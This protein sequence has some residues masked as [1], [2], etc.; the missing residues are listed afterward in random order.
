MSVTNA[1]ALHHTCILVNDL[2]KTAEQ[3]AKALGV[4]WSLWTIAPEQCFVNGE[5][6]PFSF[7]VGF[8]QIGDA[9]LELIAPADGHS[10]YNDHLKQ[11]GEGYHHICL[12]Y[13]D[14]ESMQAAK[15]EL[16]N[17]GFKTIQHGSTPGFFEFCYFELSEPNI[18]IELLYIKELPPPDSTIG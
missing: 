11:K 3:M 17:Q 2:E 8:A 10:V 4:T 7:K 9:N 18:L 14:L 15:S 13:A 1:A 6:S 5:P 12:A 16:Q